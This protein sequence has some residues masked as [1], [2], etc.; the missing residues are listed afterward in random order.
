[1]NRIF[2]IA[3]FTFLISILTSCSQITQSAK[4]AEGQVV[5]AIDTVRAHVDVDTTQTL[6]GMANTT[7]V[8]GFIR[9]G[10]KKFADYPGINL[11]FGGPMREKK[12]AVYNALEG[13][14]ADV[15][16]NPKYIV[17]ESRAFF[18]RKTT[19]QVAGFGGNLVF[20]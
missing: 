15:L 13:T 10:D 4:L 8:L 16:I 9:L 18:F 12:A 5:L 14:D 17:R 7:H 2:S 3:I 1:M 20:E 6:I 19:V 11:G